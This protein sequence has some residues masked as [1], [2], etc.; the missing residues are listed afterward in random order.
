MNIVGENAAL[1]RNI[2]KQFG[3][4]TDYSH[5]VNISADHSRV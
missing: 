2:I 4:Q 1:A 5:Y 3:T